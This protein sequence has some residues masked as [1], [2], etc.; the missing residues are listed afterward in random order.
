MT[1]SLKMYKLETSVC[2]NHIEFLK[3]YRDRVRQ[4][5]AQPVNIDFRNGGPMNR[6]VDKFIGQLN[7]LS[8]KKSVNIVIDS[9]VKEWLIEKGFDKNMGARPLARVIAENIKKPLSREMLFGKLKNGGSV[10]IDY[11]NNSIVLDCEVDKLLEE[12]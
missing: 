3:S 5:L 12:A 1:K 9:A 10:I 8:S 4:E 7:D 2:I 6:I 11:R